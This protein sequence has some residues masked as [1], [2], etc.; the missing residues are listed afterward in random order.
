[1]IEMPRR[2]LL[3]ISNLVNSSRIRSAETIEIREA[4]SFIATSVDSSISKFNWL[5]KRAARIMRSG[6]SE[7][8]CSGVTGVR[9]ICL[10]KSASPLNGSMNSGVGV[11]SSS[12]MQ[13]TV[14]SRRDKSPAILSPNS[15][16]GLRLSGSYLS[17]RYVVTSTVV[18]PRFAATVP[19]SIPVSQTFSPQTFKIFLLSSGSASVVKSK[20]FPK[21]PKIASRTGPPTS[22]NLYPADL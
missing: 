10:A 6:S 17:L 16:S 11:V 12:A 9:K 13:L 18:S 2:G 5:A 3:D 19:N 20:S 15:T 22:A 21:R 8:D 4:I 14:K 1:M 7:K